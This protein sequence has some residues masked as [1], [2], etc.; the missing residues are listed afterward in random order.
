MRDERAIAAAGIRLMNSEPESSDASNSCAADHAVENL[1]A[2]REH[3]H[4]EVDAFDL[5]LRRERNAS[6]RSYLQLA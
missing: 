2:G 1:P 6:M 5:R 3:D 4:V